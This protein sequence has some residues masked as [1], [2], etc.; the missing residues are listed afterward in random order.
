MSSVFLK[1]KSNMKKWVSIVLLFAS[2]LV[3]FWLTSDNKTPW[4]RDKNVDKNHITVMLGDVA[5]QQYNRMGF[6]G[7]MVRYHKQSNMWIVG[8][9]QGNILTFNIKGEQVWKRNFGI[10]KITAMAFSRDGERL[11]VGE[12]SPSGNVYALNIKSGELLWKIAAADGI[13]SDPAVRSYPSVTRI[14]VDVDE[15]VYFGAYRMVMNKRGQRDYFSKIFAVQTNGTVM[16]QF[17][18]QKPMDAWVNWFDLSTKEPLLSFSTSNYSV[19]EQMEYKKNIYTLDLNKLEIKIGVEI[20]PVAPFESTVIRSSPNYSDDGK[21]LVGISSD[22]RG[23]VFDESDNL[24]WQVAVARPRQIE[25]DWLTAVGRKAIATPYGVVFTTLNTFN[26]NS[27]QLSTPVEHPG[28]NAIFLFDYDGKFKAKFT[29][30]GNTEESESKGHLLATA[31]GRNLRTQNYESHG[32]LLLDLKQA[33]MV[34]FYKTQ[35]PMQ[36]VDISDDLRYMAA[37]EAPAQLENGTILGAYR[38]HI[39]QLE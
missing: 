25:D 14:L 16:W 21:Y 6:T 19:Q 11:Y 24:L 32:V 20:P 3:L 31:V 10:G 27:W 5:V 33:T 7:G 15:R 17:P 12:Q 26:R 37:I 8:T 1:K 22:G 29:A 30:G 39:W 2:W 13:G 35:G 36:A 34:D 4:Q 23:F 38:L 9:E 18:K 28:N